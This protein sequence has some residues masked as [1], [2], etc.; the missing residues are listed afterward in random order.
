MSSKRITIVVGIV[1]VL[2]L[3][4]VGYND[5][6]GTWRAQQEQ[7]QTIE[8]LDQKEEQ[9]DN[10]I[11]ETKE[12]QEKSQEEVKTLEQEKSELE[13]KK[14]ELEEQLSV[15]KLQIGGSYAII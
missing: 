13:K 5:A 14:Q 11:D 1:L 12:T 7:E 2:A 3:G 8:Q 4:A 10:E 9:L 6:V 15:N